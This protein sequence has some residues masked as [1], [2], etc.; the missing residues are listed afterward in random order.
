MKTK[1]SILTTAGLMALGL[2]SAAP[3]DN[4]GFSIGYSSGYGTYCPPSYPV[5]TYP[6]YTYPVYTYP[7]YPVYTYPTYNYCPPPRYTVRYDYD[8]YPRYRPYPRYRHY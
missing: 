4:F 7:T 5:Y 6:V 1:L 3:A 8:C 2:T